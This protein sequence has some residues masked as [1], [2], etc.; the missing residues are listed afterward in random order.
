MPVLW[1][2]ARQNPPKQESVQMSSAR[3]TERCFLVSSACCGL[4]TV[5]R[6]YVSDPSVK[7]R[8]EGTSARVQGHELAL[9]SHL[10][11]TTTPAISRVPPTRAVAI[12]VRGT[13]SRAAP[14]KARDEKGTQRSVA[15]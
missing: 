9:L 4:V 3:R 12:A 8:Y 5:F 14:T 11:P 2:P 13:P 1:A 7:N 10:A 15:V 6:S